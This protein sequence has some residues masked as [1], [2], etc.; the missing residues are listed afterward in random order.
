VGSLEGVT[1]RD[2]KQFRVSRLGLRVQGRVQVF[3]LETPNSKL[4][5]LRAGDLDDDLLFVSNDVERV[6]R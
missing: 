2:L 6:A 3:E 1:R 4:E 5:T